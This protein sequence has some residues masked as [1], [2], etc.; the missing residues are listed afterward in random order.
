MECRVCSTKGDDEDVYF[1]YDGHN[2]CSRQHLLQD[3]KTCQHCND[4]ATEPY[5]G[6][7][8][9]G[10][11]LPYQCIKCGHIWYNCSA[12]DQRSALHD[13]T[14]KTHPRLVKKGESE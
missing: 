2:Y 10:A 13:N 11:D 6:D 14:H 9:I 1:T 5:E 12:C 7:V 4:V 8:P 3:Y